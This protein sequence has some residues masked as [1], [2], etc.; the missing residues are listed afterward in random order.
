MARASLHTD[1]GEE[2]AV[3]EAGVTVLGRGAL[4][5]SDGRVFHLNRTAATPFPPLLGMFVLTFRYHADSWYLTLTHGTP[6]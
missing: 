6:F 3:F 1:T 5:Y 2:V 4:P